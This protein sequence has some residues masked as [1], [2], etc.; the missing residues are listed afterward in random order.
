MEIK[1]EEVSIA[2]AGRFLR[3]CEARADIS[4]NGEQEID[5]EIVRSVELSAVKKG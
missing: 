2:A 1:L 5:K 3:T 4:L